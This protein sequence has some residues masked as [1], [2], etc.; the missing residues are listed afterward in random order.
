MTAIAPDVQTTDEIVKLASGP[1]RML[2]V[3]L[4]A[5]KAA[6]GAVPEAGVTA[7]EAVGGL[8]GADAVT[9]RVA[10]DDLPAVSVTVAVTVYVPV[11]VYVC[12]AVACAC[13]PTQSYANLTSVHR[14]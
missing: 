1:E 6:S 2:E 8:S 11:A 7:S 12:A 9:C 13:G 4:L 5:Q 14:A 10:V 3:S